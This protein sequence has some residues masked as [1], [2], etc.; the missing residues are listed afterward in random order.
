MTGL[1]PVM[2][3][4]PTLQGGLRYGTAAS[5]EERAIAYLATEVPA[6]HAEN[7]CY[8][9]HNNGDGA[10]AL[11]VARVLSYPVPVKAL[12]DTSG[13]LSRPQSW[14]DNRG[15]PRFSDKKLARIQFA[16]SLVEALEAGAVEDN[17]A[18]FRAAELLLT[19]QEED[20]SWQVDSGAPVGSPITYGTFLATYLARRAL[21]TAR[22]SRFGE[23]IARADRWLI[24]TPVKVTL[25]A[26]A[27]A[28]ALRGSQ[29][30]EAL[31]KRH[32]CLE[33]ILHFQARDG[34]WGPYRNSPSETFDT[35]VALL[36]LCAFADEPRLVPVIERARIYL[37][38]AQLPTGGWPETTRPPD[39][40]SYAQHIS[41]TGWATLALLRSKTVTQ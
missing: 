14:D 13:W 17:S 19:H 8:S 2:A 1:L 39:G 12:S 28:L 11:Y 33:L 16:A 37:L 32:R 5:A 6:W 7:H 18:L 27:V 38:N 41:T 31:A 34:G 22:P 4:E 20:G 3:R 15:D 9:C 23:A 26:A 36:A 25:D 10:R 24:E 21:E 29:L 30:P 35:A 40:V